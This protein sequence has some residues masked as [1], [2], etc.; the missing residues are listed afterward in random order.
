MILMRTSLTSAFVSPDRPDFVTLIMDAIPYENPMGGPNYYGFDPKV[1]YQLHIAQAGHTTANAIYSVEFQTR[2][3]NPNTFLYQLGP[4]ATDRGANLNV[5]QFATVTKS[6]RGEGDTVIGTDLPVQP[7]NIG[8]HS[9]PPQIDGKDSGNSPSGVTGTAEVTA[10]QNGEG[11]FYAG[12]RG[13]PFP[14]CP[15]RVGRAVA[16]P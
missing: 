15:G 11:W 2:V 1:R 5:Q 8:P 9:N 4:Y 10:L 6:V 13:D 12:Q 7:V 14:A 16:L 3:K